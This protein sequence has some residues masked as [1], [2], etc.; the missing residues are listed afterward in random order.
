MQNQVL[1]GHVIGLVHP[2]IDAHT[3]GLSSIAQLLEDCGFGVVIAGEDV[4]EAC[5]K[6][7]APNNLSLLRTWL[8]DNRIRHLG[9]SYRLDPSAGAQAFGLLVHV[10][11]ENG[12]LAETGGP[13]RGL[14]FAGL[15]DAA[16]KVRSEHGDRAVVFM[17]DET[18]QETL[19]RIGVPPSQ[20]PIEIASQEHYEKARLDFGK[21]LLA[22]GMPDRIKPIDWSGYP[23]FGTRADSLI[24]RLRQGKRLGLPPLMRAH[25]GPYLP[26]REKAVREFLS[27]CLRLGE[28]GYLDVLSI[29]TSQLTQ[30]RFGE[31]WGGYPNGGGVPINSEEEYCRVYEASRPMLVRTYAGTSRLLE[32]AQMHDRVLNNA[33]HALS[34]WWFSQ[35]DG[36]GPNSV[37]QNL[38]DHFEVLRYLSR[39]GKPFEPNIPHHFAF[40]GSDDAT[41]VASAVLAARCA[42]RLGV[43]VLVLQNMLNTPKSTWGIQDL[44][45]ARVMLGSMRELQDGRFQVV[46][47]PRAG[48]DYF[49]PDLEKAKV[50]LAA[51]SALM[52]DVEPYNPNSPEVVHVVSYSE[53]TALADPDVINESI[54]ITRASIE[55]YR[56][57]KAR[58]L[59]DDVL[60]SEDQANRVAE[61]NE[62]VDSMLAAMEKAIPDLYTPEGLYKA[63]WAGFMPTPHLWECREE[64]AHAVSW[65]TRPIRGSMKV[66]DRDNR[67]VP[68]RQRLEI[69]S[70]IAATAS[71]PDQRGTV[72]F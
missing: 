40:R 18:P 45:K 38:R 30:S 7:R 42:K 25:V 72:W 50:Q 46:Y 58:G 20:I 62:E 8:Q 22:W 29:G 60:R 47:Q 24:A 19:L 49:S 32:L 68:I 56:K 10:L 12:L 1:K 28:G 5:Q 64:F 23:E 3:L 66:V 17:G 16:A 13:V 11:R 57:E 31:D 15:P 53:G 55:E 69:A 61:L 4:S 2:E 9:F 63:F 70:E 6:P 26:D 59:V 41:Y 21:R 48:L 54:R 35:I 36:R 27:W 52:D 65:R 51:V 67:P 34:F 33:W 44:A 14:F 39:T 71:L 37:L 43:K